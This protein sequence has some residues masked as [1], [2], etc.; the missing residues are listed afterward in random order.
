MTFPSEYPQ[1]PPKLKFVNEMWHPNIYPDGTVCIS[2]LHE[3]D[4][5]NEQES[6]T[7]Q[8]RPVLGVE[9]ILVSVISRLSEPNTNSPANLDASIQFRDDFSE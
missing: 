7:E 5:T 8:W 6:E 1:K 9:Q 3:A 2:I 4:P